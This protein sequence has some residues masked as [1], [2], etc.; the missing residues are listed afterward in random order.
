MPRETDGLPK[1]GGDMAVQP[2]TFLVLET[3]QYRQ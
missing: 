3:I 1:H 2:N